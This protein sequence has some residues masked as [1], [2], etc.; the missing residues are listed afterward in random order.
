MRPALIDTDTLSLFL[1]KNQKIVNCFNDY[2]NEIGQINI[3]IITYYEILSGL[4]Y[5]DAKNKLNLF[6]EFIK[7]LNIIHLDRSSVL[8][9]AEI[10]T[11]LRKKGMLLDDIDILIA[12]IAVSNNLV[13]VTN[14]A[15]HFERIEQITLINWTEENYK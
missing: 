2:I 3:S 4:L 5:R 14:N 15:K 6:N 7:H 10:Y 13:L 8:K 11:S 9:S 12:G 1:S